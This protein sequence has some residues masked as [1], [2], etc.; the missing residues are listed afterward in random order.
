MKNEASYTPYLGAA[1]YPEDW[2]EEQQKTDLASMKR[3]GMNVVRLAEFAWSSLEPE[4]G[5][6]TF[7]WLHEII[8]RLAE[9]GIAVVLG[10]PTCTPPLW[11]TGEHPDIFTVMSGGWRMQ[12]GARRHACPNNETYRRSCA[13]IVTKMAQ[14]FGHDKNVIGWQIDNEMIPSQPR[15]CFCPTCRKKFRERLQKKYGTIEELN[16]AWCL[17]LWS[18]EYRS[19]DDVPAPRA[20]MWHH[21]SLIQE[22]ME[23]QSDSYIEYSNLQADLLHRYAEQPVGTDMM[24]T[25][26]INYYRMNQKLDMVQFN[27][28]NNQGNL[29]Q[30]AFWMDYIRPLK[31]RPFWNMETST[32]WSGNTAVRFGYQ[33]SGF[34]TV[35][36][37]LPY[38]LGA[39]ANLYWL[40]RAHW[41]GQEM[42]HGAVVDACG[43]PLH[44]FGEVKRV[45]A[46]CEKA[47]GFLAG[48]RPERSGLALHVSCS[49]GL[50]ADAQPVLEGFSYKDALLS[51][52]YRPMLRSQLRPD[53]LEPSLLLDGYR[54]VVTPFLYN[55]DEG[56]LRGR[57]EQWVRD[58][59]TWVV[60]PMSDIRTP[61]G[62]KYT[63]SP[64]GSLER[65]AGVR[66][67]YGIPCGT[68]GVFPAQWSDGS[69][70]AGSGWFDGFE[71]PD[72]HR[73]AS[74][75]NAANELGGLAAVTCRSV[76]KGHVIVLGT[77][78][79]ESDLR[80]LLLTVC[81][82]ADI[83]PA[84]HAAPNVLAVP[85]GG[86]AGS[87]AFV[88]ELENAP[89]K[90]RLPAP[91]ENLETGEIL[92]GELEVPPYGAML[93]RSVE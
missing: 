48:T 10:T 93:L 15:G 45:A 35:N 32:C 81:A 84:F 61:V 78:P 57:L 3:C 89:G 26:G 2:P 53:L 6:Y 86:E 70:M 54:V 49:N 65:F 68:E 24:P 42:M 58:G 31:K 76:G 91:M 21:P 63:E 22:W 69:P 11:I 74:Y 13:E 8:N 67:K 1:Y 19:F 66:R 60:G 36:S 75:T 85:R 25:F 44:T 30:A 38:A 51:S 18:M 34:C 20:D 29:W 56:G 4:E 12:H 17:K 50:M 82:E 80:K 39:Q 71:T 16:R 55:L 37:L 5:R 33:P 73:L 87:G 77:I 41:A 52:F 27:H 90:I 9:Q 88:L 28:Y 83:R 14:E 23:F 64:F 46:L 79:S 40:W 62:T 43:R 92:S 59:G 72:S 47:R 7:G